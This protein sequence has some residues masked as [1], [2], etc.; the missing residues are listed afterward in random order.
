MLHC[1]I[2][3]GISKGWL[4]LSNILIKGFL[5]LVLQILLICLAAHL[6][7]KAFEDEARSVFFMHTQTLSH[8]MFILVVTLSGFGYIKFVICV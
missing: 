8:K 3:A 6:L 4:S 2:F 1:A 5:S 7:W